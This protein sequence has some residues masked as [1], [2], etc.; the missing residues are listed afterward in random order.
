[1]PYKILLQLS[2]SQI[3][4]DD[5]QTHGGKPIDMDELMRNIETV[6]RTVDMQMHMKGSDVHNVV[7]EIVFVNILIPFQICFGI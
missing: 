1:M 4:D 2:G 7:H 3:E 6:A 5:R